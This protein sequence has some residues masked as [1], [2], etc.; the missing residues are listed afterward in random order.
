MLFSLEKY[1]FVFG[2]S[3]FLVLLPTKF[4]FIFSHNLQHACELNGKI[5]ALSRCQCRDP[6]FG[7]LQMLIEHEA[8]IDAAEP[9]ADHTAFHFAC[10]EDQAD[11]AVD[12][13]VAER[14]KHT[15]VLE[16]LRALVAEQQQQQQQQQ[17][18]SS[19]KLL[20]SCASPRR[21]ETVTSCGSC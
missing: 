20:R 4:G 17:Q 16:G 12:K 3:T 18:S 9:T 14:H 8:T 7:E 15:A 1:G 11:C 6:K 21:R 2:M 19:R 5:V 13:E 10:L